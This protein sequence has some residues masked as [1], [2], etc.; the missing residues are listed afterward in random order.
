MIDV[1]RGEIEELYLQQDRHNEKLKGLY[2]RL[3]T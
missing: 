3:S 2:E 1:L